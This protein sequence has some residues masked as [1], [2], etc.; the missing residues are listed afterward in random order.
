MLPKTSFSKKH[1]SAPL[2]GQCSCCVPMETV[3]ECVCCRDYPAAVRK[4]QGRQSHPDF[5][6]LCLDPGVLQLASL[7]MRHYGERNMGATSNE[8]FRFAAYR[9]CVFWLWRRLGQKNRRPLPSCKVKAIRGH[10]ASDT[11]SGFRYPSL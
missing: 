10:F 6:G 4:Q 3:A 8:R 11:Y 1:L 7:N 9:Q 5:E 2:R